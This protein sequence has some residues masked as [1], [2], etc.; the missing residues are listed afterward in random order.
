MNARDSVVRQT[1]NRPAGYCRCGYAIDPGVCPECGR[2]VE[3]PLKRPP[4]RWRS[5]RRAAFVTV[6]LGIVVGGYFR[7]EWVA[8][9][10]TPSWM[11]AEMCA[12]HDDR[13]NWA[14]QVLWGRLQQ[15]ITRD[16][17]GNEATWAGRWWSHDLV[18]KN[19]EDYRGRFAIS[20][21]KRFICVYG[22]SQKGCPDFSIS[23]PGW[24]NA[25]TF[26]DVAIEADGHVVLRP[27]FTLPGAP[28]IIQEYWSVTLGGKRYLLNELEVPVFA[29]AMNAQISWRGD[30]VGAA[31]ATDSVPERVQRLLYTLVSARVTHVEVPQP[32]ATQAGL[33][34]LAST[35][36]ATLNAGRAEKVV[37]G[38]RFFPKR[39]AERNNAMITITHVD[40]HSA[41][42]PLTGEGAAVSSSELNEASRIGVG[43]MY[44]TKVYGT[45][46]R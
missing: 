22:H 29:N 5:C 12:Q 9:R 6:V 46:N 37:V 31:G 10:V 15:I 18:E 13:G 41:S 43:T 27:D 16:F 11:L 28:A 19:D 1:A 35:P 20:V 17:R 34:G 21:N 7:G 38:M 14:R 42:G 3:Q 25:F 30:C 24:N 36:I 39:Y 23:D 4:S 8:A 40:E 44:W 32:A 2:T 33:E 45:G 26:G